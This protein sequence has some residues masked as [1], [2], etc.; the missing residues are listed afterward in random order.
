MQPWSGGWD[1]APAALIVMV[2]HGL[3]SLIPFYSFASLVF[4]WHIF[5][6]LA[7]SNAPILSIK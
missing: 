2:G 1:A 3:S 4:H 7:F 6:S 5:F